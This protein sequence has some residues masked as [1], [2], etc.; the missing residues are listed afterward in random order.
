MDYMLYISNV[1]VK[2]ID[3]NLLRV[4]D[5]IATH[6]SVTL[7]GETLGL[8]QPAMSNA[9]SRLRRVFG[10]ELF[11]RTPAG[12]RPTPRAAQVAGSVR[13]A[14]AMLESS[15]G[16]APG[17]DPASAERVFRLS[18]S[19]LGE[20]MF[21]PPLIAALRVQA[22]RVRIETRP[23]PLSQIAAALEAGEIDLAMGSLAG[24]KRGVRGQVLFREP[25]LCVMRAGHPH[26]ARPIAR[27]ELGALEFVI[28]APAETA[29]RNVDVAL[30]RLGLASR[31]MV[32]MPHFM[33][34]PGI[35][36]KS[37]LVAIVPAMLADL[38]CRDARLVKQ[39]F[40][41]ALAAV[42]IRIFWHQR[43]A[44]DAANRWLRELVIEL[45]GK[46]A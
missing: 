4:F 21:L 8:T 9:L 15:L 27:R 38:F 24:G 43:L 13:A 36:E 11:V 18:T 16:A 44:Q 40:P 37:D 29:H 7:A 2:D 30:Q 32:R 25:Y 46:E 12:M 5:A 6:Q 14:L 31:V 19:D 20:T 45:H 35:L 42:E 22:P 39:A 1:N 34:I 23:V 17:F 28:V 33:A 26:A 3:L 41:A 10:D